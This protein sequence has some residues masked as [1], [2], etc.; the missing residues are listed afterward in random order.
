[1]GAGADQTRDG[2]LR[3]AVHEN[4]RQFEG[5]LQ[6]VRLVV[7]LDVAAVHVLP[8]AAGLLAEDCNLYKHPRHECKTREIVKPVSQCD[9]DTHI[10]R[11]AADTARNTRWG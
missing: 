6:A 4:R 5:D 1:M 7:A 3:P 9:N 10:V 8:L 11:V 2:G